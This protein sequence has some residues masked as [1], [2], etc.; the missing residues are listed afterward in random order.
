MHDATD[1]AH[2]VANIMCGMANIIHAKEIFKRENNTFSQKCK[3]LV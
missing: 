1:I 3:K 2:S